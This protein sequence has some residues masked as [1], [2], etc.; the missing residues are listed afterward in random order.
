MH[1]GP[2]AEPGTVPA[3]G[4]AGPAPT[5]PVV[6][7]AGPPEA[8]PAVV[9]APVEPEEPSNTSPKAQPPRSK[10][11]PA[12]DLIKV[13]NA[14]Q[15]VQRN[16]G[17]GV[18]A[19]KRSGLT[20]GMELR[21]VGA[22]GSNGLRK[23][24]GRATVLEVAPR[25]TLLKLDE[26]AGKAGGDRFVAMPTEAPDEASEAEAEASP[27][28]PAPPAPVEAPAKRISVGVRQ[29]GLLGINELDR[30][31]IVYN[32][33]GKALSRCKATIHRRGQY[34]FP[35]LRSKENKVK[36]GQFKPHADAPVVQEGKM[37]IECDEGRVEAEIQ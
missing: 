32:S 26:S 8:A 21:V 14:L 30:T 29:T 7:K 1:A 37:L 25:K 6:G 23:V 20:P 27:A 28:P 35:Y 17:Y 34:V 12:A 16:G 24:L 19:G 5:E 3:D 11:K 15:I 36:Q 13:K 22:A 2:P 9:T 31:F 33:E 10:P 4:T 18:A